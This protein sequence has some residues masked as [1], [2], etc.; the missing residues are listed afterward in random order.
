ML[1]GEVADEIWLVSSMNYDLG[2]FYQAENR[3]DQWVKNRSIRKS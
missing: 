2:F 3:V 1:M